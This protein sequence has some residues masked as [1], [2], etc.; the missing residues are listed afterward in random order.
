MY[1]QC[2]NCLTLYRV[3]PAELAAGRGELVCG[4]CDEVFDALATL[5]ADL[6][7]E[8]IDRLDAVP[9]QVPRPTAGDAVLRPRPP[10][11]SLFEP[12]ATTP[13]TA[14]LRRP[15]AAP[16]PAP[17]RRL[18]WWL[19]AAALAL[20]LA[21]QVAFAERERLLAV[22]TYRAWAQW[23]CE[24]VGC[25]LDASARALEGVALVS[26]DIR[27]H[28]T[29]NGAL[30]ISATLGNQSDRVRPYPLLELRLSDLESRPVAMRRFAP[31]D[32]LSDPA[33]IGRGMAPGTT[34]PV[35]FEVLD[36]GAG[37]VAFEFRLLPAQ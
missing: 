7:P 4:T 32:Y 13:G 17:R 19:A 36:P 25:T 28:P 20:L 22:P 12:A 8:P 11:P 31:R 21:L 26:R 6:P 15:N 29:V 33:R 3:G 10:Q 37:A 16:G 35:E 24:R 30:L 5:S 1:S 18:R 9:L 27:R 34:L 14:F 2:P 23:L